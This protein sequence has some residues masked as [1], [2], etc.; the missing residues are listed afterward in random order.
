M[1]THRTTHRTRFYLFVAAL[2][3]LVAWFA[4]DLN[5]WVR[6]RL[7]R[8]TTTARRSFVDCPPPSEFEQLHII[9]RRREDRIAADCWYVGTRGS[10]GSRAVRR[11]VSR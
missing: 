9:V 5:G 10:Y 1:D 7:E 3:G 11:E 6:G 4:D 2:F 8:D